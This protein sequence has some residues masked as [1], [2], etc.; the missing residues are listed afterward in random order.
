MSEVETLGDD[1]N[2]YKKY[3]K[4]FKFA[5]QEDVDLKVRRI[6]FKT[7]IICVYLGLCGISSNYVFAVFF[8]AEARDFPIYFT[9]FVSSSVFWVG[10][11]LIGFVS[12]SVRILF[13]QMFTYAYSSPLSNTGRIDRMFAVAAQIPELRVLLRDR[14]SKRG[15]VSE[16]DYQSLEIDSI[17]KELKD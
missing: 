16:M 10:L 8:N 1:Y 13:K 6:F 5:T 12:T 7:L 4:D 15:F 3:I 2:R 17:Y 14:L 9:S 11:V